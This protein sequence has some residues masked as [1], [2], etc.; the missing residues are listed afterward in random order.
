VFV[1]EII[2]VEP[3]P[4]FQTHSLYVCSHTI[5]TNESAIEFFQIFVARLAVRI[6]PWLRMK[7]GRFQADS[8]HKSLYGQFGL[9]YET[10]GYRI[11]PEAFGLYLRTVVVVVWIGRRMVC[12][13]SSDPPY[14]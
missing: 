11:P 6:E 10:E 2:Y 7:L 4:P 8:S 14:I 12:R 9:L 3:S 1:R 13:P 5:P